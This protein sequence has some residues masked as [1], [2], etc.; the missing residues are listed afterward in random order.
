MEFHFDVVQRSGIKHRA[1]DTSSRLSTN[2][3]YD[4]D[5]DD[6]P[7][8]LTILQ[9][10][11]KEKHPLPYSCQH[12]DDTIVNFELHPKF[13]DETDDGELLIID[14]F[15]LTQRKDAFCDQMKQLVVTPNF[16]LT[17]DKH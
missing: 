1:A 16:L 10:S 15:V 2:G 11:C 9:H 4:K 3:I 14:G 8:V 5:I 7:P 17:L 6:E 12:Y 13:T